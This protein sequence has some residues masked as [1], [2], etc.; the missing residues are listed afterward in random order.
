LHAFADARGIK[1]VQLALAWLAG[2]P[3]VGSVMP[4]RQAPSIAP[5][6]A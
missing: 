1:L 4:A 2:N 5:R 6:P 3:I